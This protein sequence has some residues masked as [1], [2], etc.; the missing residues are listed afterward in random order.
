[1]MKRRMSIIGIASGLLF[2][3]SCKKNECHECHYDDAN[4]TQVDLGERCGDDLEA[5]EKNGVVING[6]QYTVHCHEH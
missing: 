5:V 4:G 2:L 3:A 6:V 1:M